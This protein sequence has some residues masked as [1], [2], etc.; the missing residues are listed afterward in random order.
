M[1][2]NSL[3]MNF[4]LN[5]EPEENSLGYLLVE[6]DGYH[7]RIEERI[8][9]LEAITGRARQRYSLR[10]A[11]TLPESN[12]NSSTRGEERENSGINCSGNALR[13]A[14][15]QSDNFALREH[16]AHL[17][18]K[19]LAL[20][21]PTEKSPRSSGGGFFDCNI[22]LLMA[23]DPILTCCGHLFCWPCFY[24]LPFVNLNSTVRECPVC[25]GEIANDGG[26]TPI[27]GNGDESYELKAAMESSFRIPPRPHAHRIESTRQRR[28]SRAVPLFPMEER[29]R[30]IRDR[31]RATVQAMS[32][33]ASSLSGNEPASQADDHSTQIQLPRAFTGFPGGNRTYLTS[34]ALDS[35]ERSGDNMDSYHRSTLP[36]NIAIVELEI[37][38]PDVAAG[39]DSM[40][41]HS[42]PLST[43][44]NDAATAAVQLETQTNV[45]PT[46]RRRSSVDNGG[47]QLPRRRRMRE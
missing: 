3:T 4:D 11:R 38:G 46:S 24:Q 45:P 39:I 47:S 37:R 14:M 32:E 20:D 25:N 5:Q 34:S 7:G 8:R 40:I 18:A 27:Y 35:A 33:T 17:I 13:V 26:I 41:A 21:S 28:I 23:K 43:G 10:H 2:S 30:Q 29:I 19:A 15:F 42:S 6:L 44:Q 9:Q 36:G 16:D 31:V 12:L 22:C 1:D